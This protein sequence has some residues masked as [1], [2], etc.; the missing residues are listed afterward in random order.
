MLGPKLIAQSL[1]AN[2]WFSYGPPPQPQLANR[3]LSTAFQTRRP[4]P[5]GQGHGL[6]QGGTRQMYFEISSSWTNSMPFSTTSP[7]IFFS[8]ISFNQINEVPM[9]NKSHFPFIKNNKIAQ[10]MIK[11]LLGSDPNPDYIKSQIL[12]SLNSKTWLSQLPPNVVVIIQKGR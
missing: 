6:A 12:C 4:K 11:T 8:Y 3:I 5:K 1:F 7:H 9:W 10:V 2:C